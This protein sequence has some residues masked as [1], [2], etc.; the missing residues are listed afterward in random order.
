MAR[1]EDGKT[2]EMPEEVAVFELNKE[3]TLEEYEQ[4][5]H[6]LIPNSMED[7]WFIYLESDKLYFH[8][9]WTGNCTY[10]TTI[11]RLKN[12]Y[13]L[14]DTLVNR[15]PDQYKSISDQEDKEI[16]NYLV[17]RLLLGKKVPF[18]SEDSSLPENHNPLKHNIVG[19]GRANN[20]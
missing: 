17:D 10:I 2:N 4:L 13:M 6:G 15:N 19:Y 16:L 18:P 7:K 8:R 1:K 5:R 14:G 20:E 3:I 12:V 9:S 11:Q